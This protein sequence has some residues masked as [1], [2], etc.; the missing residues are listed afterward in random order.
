MAQSLHF[1]VVIQLMLEETSKVL[2][3]NFTG[4]TLLLIVLRG[5]SGLTKASPVPHTELLP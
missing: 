3:S 5:G 2:Y 4:A 1:V